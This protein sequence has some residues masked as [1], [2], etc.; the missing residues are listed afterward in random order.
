M[1]GTRNPPPQARF[2]RPEAGRQVSRRGRQTASE[3]ARRHRRCFNET[4][5]PVEGV[6]PPVEGVRPSEGVRWLKN[7]PMLDGVS[8]HMS[9]K[10]PPESGTRSSGGL[11]C[12]LW[13]T[14]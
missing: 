3:R 14:F 6:R 7:R 4:Y 12:V 5:R 9:W 2:A 11:L 1:S 13:Y 10:T 8:S